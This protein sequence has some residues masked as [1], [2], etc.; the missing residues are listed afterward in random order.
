MQKINLPIQPLLDLLFY[1]KKGNLAKFR[2]LTYD[3]LSSIPNVNLLL[4]Y[5]RIVYRSIFEK[6]YCLGIIEI[7]GMDKDLV[8]SMTPPIAQEL[9]SEQVLLQYPIYLRKRFNSIEVP[10][11]K[12]FDIYIKGFA[13]I[14]FSG[15][16]QKKSKLDRRIDIRSS[17]D[18]NLYN[19]LPRLEEIASEISVESEIMISNDLKLEYYNSKS[20]QWISASEKFLPEQ[21][22]FKVRQSFLNS[23]YIRRSETAN[24]I[25][26]LDRDWAFMLLRHYLKIPIKTDWD[27]IRRSLKLEPKDY[28]YLPLLIKKSLYLLSNKFPEYSSGKMVI[29]NVEKKQL[30]RYQE[31][32]E[33]NYAR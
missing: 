1:F 18:K 11:E 29:P 4:E 10:E 27:K 20:R 19:L 32:M 7:Q 23:W 33:I 30:D 17:N 12:L 13:S 16:V 3:Y 6:F 25:E 9:N 22:L 14:E 21:C 31:F 5:E 24:I 8:W 28:Y 26:I 15:A 2:E